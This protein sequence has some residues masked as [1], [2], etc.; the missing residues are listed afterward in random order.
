MRSTEVVMTG[1][2][3]PEVLATR[4][5]VVGEPGRGRVLVRTEA[6]GI[7]FAEVQMLR[8]RYLGQPRFPFVPGYDLVGRV[9][10]VGAGVDGALL[11]RRVAA[12]TRFGAWAEVVEVPARRL[13]PV[14][15]D[16]DAGD[17]VALVTNG[18]TAW[19]MVHRVARVQAGH[20]VLV[21]GASGGVG[22]LLAQLARSAG[23]RVI[24]TA[25]AGKHDVLRDLGA[26]PVD[27]RNADVASAV[28]R[29]APSGLDA[30][31]DHVGGPGLR[32]LWPLL[33]R[34]GTLV[35]YG[36]ESTLEDDSHPLLPYLPLAGRVLTWA[37]L[38]NGRRARLYYVRPT[39]TFRSDLA[40]VIALFRDGKLDAR[41]AHRL[42]LDRAAEAL[43]LLVG[44]GVA[45]K[46]VLQAR[47]GADNAS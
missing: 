16:V 46:V 31:F 38:P 30:V 45:G 23:A 19:Q 5:R 4:E 24:G 11:G 47:A 7:A 13:A 36:S 29:L 43:G 40:E 21:Q 9:V 41:V 1:P 32:S 20:T 25:S 8:G 15:E 18:V 33:R 39:A 44:G 35:S 14:P 3:G 42:P 37:L 6:A 10:A 26:E 17:A 2:G 27:Y 28:R 12:M 34:G 22:T